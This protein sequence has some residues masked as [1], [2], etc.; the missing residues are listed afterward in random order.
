M[1][2]IPGPGRHEKRI[3]HILFA[4][5][6]R[7][8]F[9]SFDLSTGGIQNGMGGA[10]VPFASRSQSWVDVG[11]ALGNLAELEGTARLNKF[12]EFK[13][14]NERL[15]FVVQMFFLLATT[16][17]VSDGSATLIVAL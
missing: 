9:Q 13:I 1:L 8:T 2:P 3:Q 4:I 15:R 10:S 5:N 14:L 11:M 6:Q 12:V 7:L 16:R 17:T